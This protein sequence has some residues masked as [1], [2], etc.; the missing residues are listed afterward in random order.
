MHSQPLSIR[1]I[2]RRTHAPNACIS[3]DLCIISMH[4]AR[5][6]IGVSWLTSFNSFTSEHTMSVCSEK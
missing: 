6:A 5:P 4:Y 1:G 2:E 3:F